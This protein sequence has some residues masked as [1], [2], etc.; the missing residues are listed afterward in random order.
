MQPVLA[1]LQQQVLQHLGAGG[2]HGMHMGRQ[3][4]S[5]GCGPSPSPAAP[6]S[7]QQLLACAAVVQ[8]SSWHT[9]LE[10]LDKSS[11]PPPCWHDVFAH[12]LLTG[13]LKAV[14]YQYHEVSRP[15]AWCFLVNVVPCCV[16][17][18]CVAE[19]CICQIPAYA[20]YN[21]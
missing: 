1:D 18:C 19:S 3:A 11:L 5:G 13:A 2:A 17:L 12:L 21:G 4:S 9:C 8:L 6:Q 20:L 16:I 10:S 7:Q 15:P 14:S